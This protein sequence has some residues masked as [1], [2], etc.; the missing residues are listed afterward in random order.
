MEHKEKVCQYSLS[1]QRH[2]S[3]GWASASFKSFLRPSRF[4]ATI[5]QFLHP[6]FAASTFTPSCQRSLGLLLGRFPPGSLRRTL[7]DKSSSSWRM[8][9]P[10]HVPVL[11]QDI[12]CVDQDLNRPFP[13]K[14]H[15]WHYLS[16]R[17][18]SI[19]T[20][21]SVQHDGAITYVI[22]TNA[23]LKMLFV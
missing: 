7:L 4:R 10:A 20:I 15:D 16:Q 1:L 9:C 11:V 17:A 5:V 14:R 21:Y 6:S 22:P 23:P 2:Y 8:T 3:P 18:R 19:C 13:H 12:Y